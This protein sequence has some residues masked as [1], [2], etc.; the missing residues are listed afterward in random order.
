MPENRGHATTPQQG[1]S[2]LRYAADRDYA[3][4]IRCP[5]RRPL[6]SALSGTRQKPNPHS[7]RGP[8]ATIHQPQNR[9]PL[10]PGATVGK[11]PS[12]SNHQTTIANSPVP[13]DRVH[14]W[15]RPAHTLSRSRRE[16]LP[17]TTQVE[18]SRVF[19]HLVVCDRCAPPTPRRCLPGQPGCGS[20][21]YETGCRGCIRSCGALS[22]FHIR[23]CRGRRQQCLSTAAARLASVSCRNILQYTDFRRR[24]DE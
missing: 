21:R 15:Y 9:T 20:A 3:P 6:A 4:D 23:R 24:D 11:P 13:G 16:T 1:L 12:A 19:A 8:P 2:R 22:W 18:A 7:T 14:P 17:P 10:A 5:F